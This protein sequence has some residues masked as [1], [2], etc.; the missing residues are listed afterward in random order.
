MFRM[1]NVFK[2]VLEQLHVGVWQRNGTSKTNIPWVAK[3][4][5]LLA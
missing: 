5:S 4:D 1:R 3:R 2:I